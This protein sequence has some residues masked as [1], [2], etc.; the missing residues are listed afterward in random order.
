VRD[1]GLCS[2]ARKGQIAGTGKAKT[3]RYIDDWLRFGR[4]MTIFSPTTGR[5]Y[6]GC[7]KEPT[8]AAGIIDILDVILIDRSE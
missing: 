7:F 3:P 6:C 1:G 5:H 2:S 4:T 8:T